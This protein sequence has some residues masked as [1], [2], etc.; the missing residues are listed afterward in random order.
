MHIRRIHVEAASTTAYSSCYVTYNRFLI[1]EQ[2]CTKSVIYSMNTME[3]LLPV[4]QHGVVDNCFIVGVLA[5]SRFALRVFS[6]CTAVMEWKNYHAVC[7]V[8]TQ[9]FEPSKKVLLYCA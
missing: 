5:Q 7:T 1:R 9:V 3:L 2:A 4:G 8:S 6:N